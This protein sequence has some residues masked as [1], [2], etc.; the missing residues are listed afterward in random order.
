MFALFSVLGISLQN[1]SHD[2]ADLKMHLARMHAEYQN[3]G[4]TQATIRHVVD[5]YLGRNGSDRISNDPSVLAKLIVSIVAGSCDFVYSRILDSGVY[6]NT[7]VQ[8]LPLRSKTDQLRSH[9]PS[10]SASANSKRRIQSSVM[11]PMESTLHLS[12]LT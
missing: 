12:L 7:L 1:L 5:F 4:V 3:E 2:A 9:P 6:L 10:T 11:W 8:P